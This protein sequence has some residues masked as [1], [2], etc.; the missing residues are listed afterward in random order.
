MATDLMRYDQMN[1][2]SVAE[3]VDDFFDQTFKALSRRPFATRWMDSTGNLPLDVSQTDDALI[4]RAS[5]A[6]YSADDIEVQVHQGVL[7]IKAERPYEEAAAG[8]R[9]HRRERP[10]GPVSRRIS[11][12]GI[13]HD[14]DVKA[15]FAN[16]LL[17]LTIPFP[18]Q[19]KPKSIPVSSD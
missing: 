6:G 17:T 19:A 13:I 1:P 3:A 10:W 2:A 5:L 8:E 11:L 14:A 4:V 15:Q 12:P 7:A 16:G 18:E 9:Y